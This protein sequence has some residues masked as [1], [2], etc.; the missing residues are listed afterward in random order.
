MCQISSSTST[1]ETLVKS[2]FQKTKIRKYLKALSEESINY[3]E[4]Q[5]IINLTKVE[6]KGNIKSKSL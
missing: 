2:F 3:I 6:Q 1:V 5:L 4:H